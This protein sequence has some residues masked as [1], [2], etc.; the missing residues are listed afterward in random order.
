MHGGYIRSFIE[1]DIRLGIDGQQIDPPP[2]AIGVVIERLFRKH[3]RTS[4][5]Q[6]DNR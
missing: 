1:R 5:N 3:I 4:A 2:P 6:G